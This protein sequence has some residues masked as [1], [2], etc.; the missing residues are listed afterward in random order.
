M[1]DE[2]LLLS[3]KELSEL[4]DNELI[5]GRWYYNP[6][7]IMRKTLAKVLSIIEKE[8]DALSYTKGLLDGRNK[9]REKIIDWID[10]LTFYDDAEGEA[11]KS[12]ARHIKNFLK[13]D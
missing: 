4:K 13:G 10:K 2:E 1:T 11:A 7:E 5:D 6:Y 3:P 8:T 9:E 12:M